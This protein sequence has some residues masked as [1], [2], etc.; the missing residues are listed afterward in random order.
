M[1]N[2]SLKHI[3]FTEDFRKDAMNPSKSIEMSSF[4]LGEY[5]NDVPREKKN[6]DGTHV[7]IKYI[8]YDYMKYYTIIPTDKGDKRASDSV[9]PSP[10]TKAFNME[11]VYDKPNSLLHLYIM[12]KSSSGVL[13]DG[14]FE[15]DKFKI[16]YILYRDILAD[17]ERLAFVIYN[18][19][20]EKNSSN[21]V[22]HPL[23]LSKFNNLVTV[24]IPFKCEVITNMDKDTSH[25]EGAGVDYMNYYS[26][27]E[28]K[29][30]SVYV[31]KESWMRHYYNNISSSS[32]M[33]GSLTV[34]KFGLKLY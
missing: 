13:N 8:N 17:A 31:G 15:S 30:N 28:S 27:P 12:P 18:E 19:D 9:T 21:M 14:L 16:L 26:I 1:E 4:R 32:P 25:L 24:K 2:A 6:E 29:Y 10:S 33:I 23:N 20:I 5:S 34:N 7:G 22:L 11:G 3:Y